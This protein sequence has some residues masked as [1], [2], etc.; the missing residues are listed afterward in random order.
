MG[1]TG[2]G[3][4]AIA[5]QIAKE[6]KGE[7]ISVDSAQVYR[8]MDIGTAKPSQKEQKE[9]PHHLID[10]RDPKEPYS[11]ADFR[12]D[13]ILAI[14]DILSRGKQPLLVGGTML[15]FKAL[16]EG[17][18]DLPSANEQIREKIKKEAE[19]T[20][21]QEL[22]AR[23]EKIDPLSAKRIHPNDPQRILRALEVYDVSG[24]TL[25]ELFSEEDK[26]KPLYEFINIAITPNDR[27]VLHQRIEKRFDQMLENGFIDEVKKLYNRGDL[28]PDLPSIRSVGYRQAW[29]Y[30]SE[31]TDYQAMREKAI[32]ATRQLAKRQL[33]WLRSWPEIIWLDSESTISETLALI[34]AQQK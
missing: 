31:K 21:W 34:R 10:I 24:K 22:H 15:Y 32:I 13:A 2:A 27:A 7:I 1:P 17:L 30:L 16:Q 18:S 12:R 6:I 8:G 25:T 11:A 14:E 23:L 9:I 5:M 3:K 29:D 20:G 28:S 33:T 19:K 26:N 4:S